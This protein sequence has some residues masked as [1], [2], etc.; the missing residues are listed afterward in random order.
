MRKAIESGMDA[1]EPLSASV[2][3]PLSQSA[4]HVLSYAADESER[5]DH[6]HIGTEHLLLGLLR[7]EQ[8][9]AGRVLADHGVTVDKVKVA[10]GNATTSA[11]ASSPSP[12]S[13]AMNLALIG[14]F[15]AL[16]EVLTQRGVL[17]PEESAAVLNWRPLHVSIYAL[18]EMLVNKGIITEAE[19]QDILNSGR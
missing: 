7:A 14:P 4:K 18:L 17:L 12:S 3:L 8:S 6:R 15:N 10:S 2:D 11:A 9:L 5:L 1:G 13:E 19:R 16:L